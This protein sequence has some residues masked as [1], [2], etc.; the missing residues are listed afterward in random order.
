MRRGAH[1]L[2]A[3][4][5]IAAVL[6]VWAPVTNPAGGPTP[7]TMPPTRLRV[8]N[9]PVPLAVEDLDAPRLSWQMRDPDP[10]EQQTAYQVLVA[11]HPQRLPSTPELTAG[12]R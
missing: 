12:R 8:E 3:V 11:T 7:S 9:Q 5:L 4:S 6:L 10:D 1:R 2:A